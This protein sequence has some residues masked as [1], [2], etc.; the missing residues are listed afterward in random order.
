MWLV[1]GRIPGEEK[2]RTVPGYHR[3]LVALQC[4]YSVTD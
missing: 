2:G 4:K 3:L 1:N